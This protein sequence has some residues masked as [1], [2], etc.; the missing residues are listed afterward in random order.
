MVEIREEQPDDVPAIRE[1]NRHAFGQDAEGALVDA[2]RGSG[3]ALLSLVAVLDGGVVGHIMFSP[4]RVGDVTGAALAPM[5]VLPG[6]QRGGIGSQLVRPGIRRLEE[7]ACPFVLVLGHARYYPRFG[8]TPASGRGITCEWEVPDD[9]F[10]VL[11]LDSVGMASVSGRAMY[12][13]EFST[14]AWRKHA[15]GAGRV[16]GNGGAAVTW[17]S[18]TGSPLR[19]RTGNAAGF[20]MS[21]AH[22]ARAAVAALQKRPDQRLQP[23]A[24]LPQSAMP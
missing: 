10:M 9:A 16:P 18:A 7:S 3:A 15:A 2:L 12:R 20:M 19:A 4:V 1:V 22:A 5:A 13:P 24:G 8:F 11:V 17:Q 14:L 21:V 23:Q 6:P